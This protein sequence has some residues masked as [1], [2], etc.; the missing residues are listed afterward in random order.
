MERARGGGGGVRKNVAEGMPSV[1]TPLLLF[2]GL[3][4]IIVQSVLEI[5]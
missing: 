3:D 5:L 4:A 1:L 2:G